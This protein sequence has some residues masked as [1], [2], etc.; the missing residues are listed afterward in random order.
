VVVLEEGEVAYVVFAGEVEVGRVRF[1]G[2][3][4]RL[5][6]A[7]GLNCSWL[8]RCPKVCGDVFEGGQIYLLDSDGC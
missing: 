5:K 4:L 3:G 8:D 7:V 2:V 6:A 1:L